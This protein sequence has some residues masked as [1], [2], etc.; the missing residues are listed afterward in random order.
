MAKDW[1]SGMVTFH[2]RATSCVRVSPC[3]L[4][5]F[6]FFAIVIDQLIKIILHI[7]ISLYAIYIFISCYAIVIVQLIKIAWMSAA[8]GMPDHQFAT[9]C[10]HD[11]IGAASGEAQVRNEAWEEATARRCARGDGRPWRRQPAHGVEAK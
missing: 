5:I 4:F 9:V 8:A 6:I 7:F 3:H 1:H 2:G 10:F 11:A